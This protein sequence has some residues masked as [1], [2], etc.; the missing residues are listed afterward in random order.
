MIKSIKKLMR[1]QITLY[2]AHVYFNIYMLKSVFFEGRII[3]LIEK[4]YN[5]LK[6]IY[7]TLTLIKL[8][9]SKTFP[10][11]LLYT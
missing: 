7:E 3:K 4:Q 1:T 9:L 2:Q 10:K 8:K 5:E 6:R 11:K